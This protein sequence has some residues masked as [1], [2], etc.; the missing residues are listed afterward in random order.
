MVVM[1]TNDCAKQRYCGHETFVVLEMWASNVSPFAKTRGVGVDTQTLLYR[2]VAMHG[3]Q[4]P[5]P[6][7]SMNFS[8]SNSLFHPNGMCA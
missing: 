6:P 5:V 2:S 3:L 1:S 7:F 8:T 4:Q